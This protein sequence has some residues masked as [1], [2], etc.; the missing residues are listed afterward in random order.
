M[1]NPATF[2]YWC[3]LVAIASGASAQQSMPT[4]PEYYAALEEWI[5][6]E[7]VGIDD[8]R[9]QLT[10]APLRELGERSTQSRNLIDR[11]R[12]VA[13]IELRYAKGWAYFDDESDQQ[14]RLTLKEGRSRLRV[15]QIVEIG[16]AD[17]FR[18]GYDRSTVQVRNSLGA[19]VTATKWTFKGWVLVRVTGFREENSPAT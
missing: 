8:S 13:I 4:P 15:G 6:G 18:G 17:S 10:I 12:P 7:I 1:I 3:L 14:I 2:T 16:R 5:E 11:E 9:G 19:A